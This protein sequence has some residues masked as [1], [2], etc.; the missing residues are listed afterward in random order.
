VGT[1]GV[2]AYRA[3]TSRTL[4]VTDGAVTKKSSTFKVVAGKTLGSFA[5][6]NPGPRTAGLLFSPSVTALDR[7]GNTMTGYAGGAKLSGNLSSSVSG[8]GTGATSPCPP[9][10]GTLSFSAGVGTASVTAYRAET[11]R[12]LTVTDGAVT[13]TSAAFKVVAGAASNLRFTTGP[14][15]ITTTKLSKTMTVQVTDPYAN[16]VSTATSLPLFPST[17][18]SGGTFW[19][20]AGTSQISDL[21]VSAGSQSV[22]FRY[23]D[24]VPGTPVITVADEA[25]GT[26]TGLVDAAQ[27]EVVTSGPS[28]WWRVL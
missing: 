9:L 22:S 13:T 3:E 28:N 18:S 24:S 17:T 14:Q 23:G 25:G 1:A 26:D 8:C 5:I 15:T 12:T 20:S 27:S 7:Y 2:T 10:F 4:T 11:G 16:P 19:N 6:S 21:V